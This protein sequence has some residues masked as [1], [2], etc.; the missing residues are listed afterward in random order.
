MLADYSATVKYRSSPNF[1]ASKVVSNITKP[2]S[3]IKGQNIT[4]GVEDSPYWL[5]Q[6]KHQGVSAFH[7]GNG[8]YQVFRNVKDFGAK[9][10]GITDDT[11]AINNAISAGGRCGPGSCQSSTTTPATV[12]FPSG[13]YLISSSI[14]DYY[15]TQLIGNPNGLP[16][17]K[18]TTDFN[19]FGFIDGNRYGPGGILSFRSTNVFYRQV[20]NFVFDFSNLPASASVTGIHWPTAQATSIQSCFFRMS[21]QKGTQH[22]GI[23]IESGSGGFMNDLQFR[24]G[25]IGISVGNQQFTM[26]NLAFLDCVTAINQFWSWGWTYSGISVTNCTT[27]LNF[28]SGSSSG[29]TVGSITLIDSKF[30]ETGTAIITAHNLT[31]SPTT[32]GSF[33]LENV[34]F[35][36]VGIIIEGPDSTLIQGGTVLLAGWGQGHQYTPRGPT[37]FQG[38]FQPF[39]R[40]QSLVGDGIVG[41]SYYHRSKPQYANEPVSSFLSIRSFNGKG[42]GVSDDTVALNALFRTAAANNKIAFIDAGTYIVTSSIYIPKDS[43]V[44]GEAYPVI[45]GYGGD[46][47]NPDDPQCVLCVGYPGDTGITELSDLILSTQGPAAGAILIRWNLA[48]PPNNPSG[49]W[50]V[51]TRVG[52]FTGSKLTST[53]CPASLTSTIINPSCIAAFMH[54]HIPHT[55]SGLYIENSWLWTADHDMDSPSLD[56]ITVYSG[57]G[58][59]CQ[60]KS[61]NIW[62]VG[63]ASEHHTLYQ[64]QF[65]NTKNIF[66]G[67]LQTETAYYQPSPDALQPFAKQNF[68]KDPD[69]NRKCNGIEGNCA[70]GWG[71]RIVNSKD[72]AIYG[73]GLY[74][75]FNNYSTL[76]SEHNST[77]LCQSRIFSLEGRSS[78]IH[79]YNLNTIGVEEMITRDGVEIAAK[80]DNGN[81]FPET[82]AVFR[83]E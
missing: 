29:Q 37:N 15:Y 10:D 21:V 83:S 71:M 49:M 20:R 47:I 55:A 27:G 2:V 69:F 34:V 31:S 18:A 38:T 58:L 57:R 12:Y 1:A 46:F 61:G 16:V 11:A 68:W 66:A 6:I 41:N 42:D 44:V 74:S 43:R 13:T 51:H 25:L 28:S 30:L 59:Y 80:K 45:M 53:E 8:T 17:L 23:F 5:A 50:D 60:S 48:S 40:P 4:G 82:V 14:I 73:V 64:Y 72:L 78:N 76:C 7:P 70:E 24:G 22:Q 36:T 9:G 33:V 67:Q 81:V 19:G 32:G 26:R 75:F 35:D 54:I 79:V 52:G 62:I 63:G 3:R 39:I 56:R 77:S 65:A